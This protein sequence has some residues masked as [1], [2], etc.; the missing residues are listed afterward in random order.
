MNEKILITINGTQGDMPEEAIQTIQQ[1]KYRFV[2]GKHMCTYNEIIE[3]DDENA[4]ETLTNLLKIDKDCV[5][6]TKR[7]STSTEMFFKKGTQHTGI[8]ETPFGSL[9]MSLFTNYL[10]IAE[11]KDTIDV[12]IEYG[13]EMNYSHVSDNKIHIQIRSI[14]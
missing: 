4:S 10:S 7:G 2:G 9:Q 8:Y 1:G 3:S 12:E 14:E 5:T 6:L 11:E 13:L